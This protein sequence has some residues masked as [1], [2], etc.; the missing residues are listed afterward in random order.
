M[1]NAPSTKPS[2]G[3]SRNDGTRSAIAPFSSACAIESW[4]GIT[5]A[6]CWR[7]SKGSL[8]DDEDTKGFKGHRGCDMSLRVLLEP[9]VSLVFLCV[10]VMSKVVGIDLGT[11]N[12]LVAYV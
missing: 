10:L 5:S 4:S 6:T 3:S 7:G 12:S 2:C 1:P 9:F 8:T 11:T